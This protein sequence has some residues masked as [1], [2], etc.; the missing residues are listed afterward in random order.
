MNASIIQT[1]FLWVLLLLTVSLIV[2]VMYKT[3]TM[4]HFS[5]GTIAG[6]SLSDMTTQALDAAPT[7]S[8]AKDRYK[9]LL[10]FCDADIRQQGTKGLR[11]LADFRDRLFGPVSFRSDLTVDDFMTPWPTWLPPLDPTIKEPVPD[12]SA[13]VAAEANLLAYLQKNFPQED[14]VDEQ[15]GATI[16]NLV[17]DFGHRF[18]F[19]PDT[20]VQ[21]KADFLATPLLQ[22]WSNPVM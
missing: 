20:S 7:T 17:E 12:V 21:L 3:Q 16:R 10:V 6:L 9:T 4:E 2:L 1:L 5:A 18:V 15:T 14:M 22:N 13:A 8:E 19:G 11:I